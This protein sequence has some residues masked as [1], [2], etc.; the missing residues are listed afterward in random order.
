MSFLTEIKAKI[1]DDVFFI[2]DKLAEKELASAKQMDLVDPS[3]HQKRWYRM[4][5]SASSVIEQAEL[6]E[7]RGLAIHPIDVVNILFK[8]KILF[9]TNSEDEYDQRVG[10]T[11]LGRQT[12]RPRWSDKSKNIDALMEEKFDDL[13]KSIEE[14]I[15]LTEVSNFRSME[16]DDTKARDEQQVFFDDLFKELDGSFECF[17]SDSTITATH[18]TCEPYLTNYTLEDSKKFL[19]APS[20]GF[21]C[22]GSYFYCY[23]KS[24]SYLR[25]LFNV[26]RISGFINPAQIDFGTSSVFTAPTSPVFLG[27]HA[28]GTLCWQEDER[29]PNEKIPDGT[30]F[31]SFGY[32]GLADMWL[33]SRSFTGMSNTILETKQLFSKL[34]NPWQSK[35]RDDIYPV[36]DLLSSVTQLPD[37]GAK[38]LLLYCSLEHLFVPKDTQRENKAHI[39]GGIN[40]LNPSLIPWF[41][42]LYKMRNAYAHK[43]F[44]LKDKQSHGMIVKSLKNI[45]VLLNAKINA[46]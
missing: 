26:I 18:K 19:V 6:F 11:S 40:A 12:F 34:S 37:I 1:G 23:L 38:L 8:C 43:G 36:L 31:L 2:L 10:G 20:I 7:S 35:C 30:L 3:S 14:H 39:V 17:L 45:L 24:V 5:I 41:N 33:D 29:V 13:Q 44:V 22:S 27:D 46:S 42:D 15:L 9:A 25:T 32:R 4:N 28:M 21:R 16:Q